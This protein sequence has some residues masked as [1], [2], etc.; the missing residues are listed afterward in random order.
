MTAPKILIADSI[1]QRGVAELVRDGALE[2]STQL[3][4]SESQLEQAFRSAVKL[5]S[6]DLARH[7][8]QSLVARPAS[9]DRPDRFPLFTF[10]IQRAL[11]DADTD[12]A[13]KLVSDG[14]SFDQSINEG[15]RHGDYELRLAQIHVRRGEVDLAQGVF[16]RLI[17]SA[18]DGGRDVFHL[19]L[20]A[21]Q[22]F[23]RH[24]RAY[25]HLTLG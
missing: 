11:T 22:L 20:I 15:R 6:Q 4:L 18:P 5:D 14:D 3:G 9:P 17:E 25:R 7:F 12:L 24:A 16:N 21:T 8:A 23:W 13:L 1:S 10:L 19:A 2:I